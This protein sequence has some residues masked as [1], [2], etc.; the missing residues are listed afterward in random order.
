MPKQSDNTQ[1]V[2]RKTGKR[3]VLHTGAMNNLIWD[4]KK[5]IEDGKYNEWL[6]YHFPKYRRYYREVEL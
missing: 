2:K 3:F 4:I 1:M 6:E 5:A